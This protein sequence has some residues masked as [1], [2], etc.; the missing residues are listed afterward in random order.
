MSTKNVLGRG[1]GAPLTEESTA[2]EEQLFLCDIDKISANQH[3]P[4]S[5]LD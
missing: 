2:A 4:R 3:Q 1:A 5:Y